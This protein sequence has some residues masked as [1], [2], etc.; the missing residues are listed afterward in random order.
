[1]TPMFLQRWQL[2]APEPQTSQ[3]KIWYR[4][5]SSSGWTNWKDPTFEIIKKH[6]QYRLGYYGKAVYV[7][8][9]AARELLN[10]NLDNESMKEIDL[11]K[12]YVN[13]EKIIV[14]LCAR[15][16]KKPIA[17][18]FSLVILSAKNFS[19]RKEKGYYGKITRL[20]FPESKM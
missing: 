1:M 4:C 15:D 6:Q 7:F 17:T 20:N 14:S 5:E 16:I 8:N 9:G 18:Q 12:E 11:K 2:F 19:Q 13:T 3:I 10:S